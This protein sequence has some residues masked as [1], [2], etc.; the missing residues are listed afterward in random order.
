[1][2]IFL[3]ITYP[4][5]FTVFPLVLSCGSAKCR[6]EGQVVCLAKH[7]STD[8]RELAL[9][10]LRLKFQPCAPVEI[11]GSSLHHL[12]CCANIQNCTTNMAWPQMMSLCR[13]TVSIRILWTSIYIA[14]P[15]WLLIVYWILL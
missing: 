11:Q 1:M 3:Q 15:S 14:G 4:Q 6:A 13:A 9:R 12:K 2:I 5:L 7:Y 10:K 8:N